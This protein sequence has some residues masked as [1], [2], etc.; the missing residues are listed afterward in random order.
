MTTTA[1]SRRLG[2]TLIAAGAMTAACAGIW[3]GA[4]ASAAP[5][6]NGTVK[7]STVDVD[8]VND[9]DSSNH[10]HIDGTAFTVEWFGFDAGTRTATVLFEAQP[11][12]GTTVVPALTGAL[13]LTF[14]ASGDAG[15]LNHAET[16]TLDLT[17]LVAHEVQ[18]YHVKVT[19]TTDLSQGNDTKSKVFW[20]QGPTPTESP[21]PTPEPTTA[22]PT[23]SEEPT[24]EPTVLPTVLTQTP[25]ISP[26]VQG[27]KI[28]KSLPH[29]GGGP[30][31]PLVVTGLGLIGLGIVLIRRP[32]GAHLR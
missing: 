15:V 8:D 3:S 16:Y 26:S 1:P 25:S 6:N 18:G 28:V 21:T 32:R 30:V 12:T 5:G 23:P 9:P 17:G 22:S 20:V 29:T 24:E 14:A 2:A 10:P 11:P 7:I 31:A 27:V 13:A 4:S 19:V